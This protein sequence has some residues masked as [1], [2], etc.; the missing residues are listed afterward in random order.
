MHRF[1]D[2]GGLRVH[3]A[4]AGEGS[5]VL[6]LHGW[7]QNHHMWHRVIGRMGQSHRLI[8]PDLRGFG[9]TDA[10]GEGYD[11]ATFAASSTRSGSSTRAWSAM[12]GVG[13]PRSSS[14]C[15]VPTASAPSSPAA[16]PT[17]GRRSASRV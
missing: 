2:A 4:E 7:P 13:S 11:P 17:P 16:P 6:L 8:A 15:A 3:Y 12:I 9:W 1:V 14:V 10:P 5:P